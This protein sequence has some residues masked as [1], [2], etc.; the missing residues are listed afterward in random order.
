MPL[1]KQLIANQCQ[2]KDSHLQLRPEISKKSID[3]Q[4][5]VSSFPAKKQK[6]LFCEKMDSHVFANGEFFKTVHFL[7][8]GRSLSPIV[9]FHSSFKP[10]K[11][12]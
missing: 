7:I 2:I 8:K 12:N 10:W 5:L 11:V 9:N 4:G 1:N 6:T 3:S